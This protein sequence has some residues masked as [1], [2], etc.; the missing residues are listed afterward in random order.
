LVTFF[1]E[2][3]NHEFR[4]HI[5]G[6]A[7]DSMGR[8]EAYHWPGNV[9]E[10]RNAVERAM[11]LADSE[12]LTRIDFL[13]LD[14]G[15]SVSQGAFQLPAEGLDFA[16]LERDLVRQALERVGGNQTRAAKLL[17]MTRDQMR[18]RV[19]KFDL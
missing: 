6:V 17:G 13:M 11:L 4:K 7:D 16:E 19:D 3:F 18:Y 9:R 8:L 14:G 12:V 2:R 5:R 1:I 15:L 10:L